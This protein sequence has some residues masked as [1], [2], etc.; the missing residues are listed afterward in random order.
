MSKHFLQLTCFAIFALFTHTAFA[1]TGTQEISG[2]L[3]GFSHP[4]LGLDHTLVMLGVGLWASRLSKF[5]A[6]MTIAAFLSFMLIGAGLA[7][8]GIT[9]EY[10]ETGILGSVLMV[11]LLLSL[12]KQLPIFLTGC[13]LASFALLHGFAHG[14]E[15]P[16]AVAPIQ[17]ALGFLIATALLHSLGF[18]SGAFLNKHQLG[19][20]VA[21]FIMGGVGLY[22]LISA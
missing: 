8:Y 1:H 19:V 22:L 21:G 20:R 11:G 10:V 7:L 17:Y 9:I 18:G 4:F 15:I 6:S 12:S 13:L 3:S 2:F 16:L 5:N 14:L